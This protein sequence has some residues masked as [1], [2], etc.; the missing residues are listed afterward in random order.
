MNPPT[1]HQEFLN[2]F[3][4]IPP[5][6]ED[7]VPDRSPRNSLAGL[8]SLA[9]RLRDQ[10]KAADMSELS[11]AKTFLTTLDAK[12]TKYS[13]NHVFDPKTFQTRIPLCVPESSCMPS[14]PQASLANTHFC[15][16]VHA[17]K[18]FFSAAP[19][20]S[21]NILNTRRARLH[22]RHSRSHYTIKVNA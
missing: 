12:N 22:L 14:S 4:A 5:A 6:P 15:L 16:T 21:K 2:T 10:L 11:F 1:L 17:P 18:A 3:A 7:T 13:P 20:T 19:S 9:K 8:G